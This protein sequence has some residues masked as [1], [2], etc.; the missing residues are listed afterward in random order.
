MCGVDHL[1]CPAP[2]I[3]VAHHAALPDVSVRR[4]AFADFPFAE[5]EPVTQHEAEDLRGR[6]SRVACKLFQATLLSRA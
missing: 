6:T 2:G 5:L 4:K 1:T 3:L